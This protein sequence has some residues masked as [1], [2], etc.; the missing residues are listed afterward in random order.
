MLLCCCIAFCI[1]SLRSLLVPVVMKSRCAHTVDGSRLQAAV[2]AREG[3]TLSDRVSAP[4]LGGK[5]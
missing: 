1:N 5:K 3:H 4:F 2:G